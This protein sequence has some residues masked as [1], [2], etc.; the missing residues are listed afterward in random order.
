MTHPDG[1]EGPL[2]EFA[3]LRSEIENRV[4][5]QQGFQTL[6]ITAI[7]AIFSFALSQA[8]YIGILLTVPAI[9]YL[10]CGRFVAQHH[11]IMRIALISMTNSV[12]ASPAG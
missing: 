6:Q 4:Q 10:F 12:I 3:A 7:A 1:Y 8:R 11:G 5:C 9:S 2:A